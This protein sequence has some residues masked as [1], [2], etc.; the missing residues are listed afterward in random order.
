MLRGN[1]L[2]L[3]A[4][5]IALGGTAVAATIANNS[6]TTKSVK[7]ATLSGIDVKN[8][9][10]TGADV[11][12]SSLQGV[13]GPKG[14]TG[15][16]GTAGAPGPG[17]RRLQ[18]ESGPT[19]GTTTLATIG[20]LTLTADCSVQGSDLRARLLADTT[21]VGSLTV[22]EETYRDGTTSPELTD[23]AP[24]QPFPVGSATLAA[25]DADDAA[26]PPREA[27]VIDAIYTSGANS[28]FIHATVAV[29]DVVAG[30]T[31]SCSVVGYAFP[32]S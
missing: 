2:G 9:S 24:A 26:V 16:P 15:P 5:F 27:R 21:A 4:I 29:A 20:S 13:Q 11:L 22:R 6:V 30:P 3:I 12:E 14:D 17:A 10:L 18:Y 1:A 28:V 8:N 31:G 23:P 25:A 32:L 7:N 19:A